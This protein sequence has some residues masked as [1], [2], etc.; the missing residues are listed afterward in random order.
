MLPFSVLFKPGV[1][2]HTQ[3]AYAARKAIVAGHL[4]PG[5]RFPSVRVLSQ[6]LKINPN[7]AHKV[8]ARLVEEGL[9]EVRPGV[10]TLVSSSTQ[11]SEA[12]RQKL[13]GD[14]LEQVVVAAR[15]MNLSLD[16][17]Q[18]ALTR[19]WSRLDPDTKSKGD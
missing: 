10:G 19:H 11:V 12:E 9:L 6:E 3:V 1:P 8:V 5:D 17:V 14:P 15:Q 2:A 7:T 18:A 13:L 16:E 4:K